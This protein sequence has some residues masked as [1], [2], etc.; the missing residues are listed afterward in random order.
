MELRI[1]EA[2][3]AHVRAGYACPC[4]C[5]PSVEYTRGSDLA[6]E[7]CCC[8]N[9]FAVGPGAS[10]NLT[11]KPGFR[12]EGQAFDTPWGERLQAAWL[13]GPSVHGPSVDHDQHEHG[14]HG[15]GHQDRATQGTDP[16]CGMTVDPATADA[17]GLH[18]TYK[19]TDYFF[20]GKGCKLEFDDDP[21]RYLD[22]SYVPSM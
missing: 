19:G 21:E 4:G 16:V 2:T 13:V 15:A 5:T 14:D 10:T 9:H 3:P 18:S 7:G 20:C 11:S 22:P 17:K 1:L 6:E 8:G 12:A